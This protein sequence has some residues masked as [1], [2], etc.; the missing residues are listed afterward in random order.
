MKE[1]NLIKILSIYTQPAPIIWLP[2]SF[3]GNK[4]LLY[5]TGSIIYMPINEKYLF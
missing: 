5:P 2:Q 4:I 3:S 1:N